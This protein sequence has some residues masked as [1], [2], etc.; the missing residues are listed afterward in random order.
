MYNEDGA[1]ALDNRNLTVDVDFNDELK[2]LREEG[3]NGGTGE[4]DG[5]SDR[6]NS[7]G[8]SINSDEIGNNMSIDED[9]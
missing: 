8:I 1:V 7:S 6:H 3:L 9:V 2:A 5:N 4:Q